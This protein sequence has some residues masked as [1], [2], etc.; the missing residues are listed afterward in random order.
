MVGA[1]GVDAWRHLDGRRDHALLAGLP[2]LL[3]AHQAIEAFVW[4][5]AEGLVPHEVA[6]IALWGYLLI[7]FVV[8]PL[9]IPIAVLAI[10]PTGERRARLAP[11]VGIGAAVAAV[12]L[13]AMARGPIG[14]TEE[15]YHSRTTRT[16]ATAAS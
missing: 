7:A 2:L 15:S 12:L 9:F 13:V 10:E 8:L 1:I 3:G 14:A 11:F 4:W 6:R 16:S 5:G